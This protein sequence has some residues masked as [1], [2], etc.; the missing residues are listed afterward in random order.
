M[1]GRGYATADSL[2]PPATLCAALRAFRLRF[3]EA[4]G[5]VRTTPCQDAVTSR[6]DDTADKSGLKRADAEKLEN[7]PIVRRAWGLRG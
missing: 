1:A 6:E 2:T 5:F 4:T 3:S 7:R